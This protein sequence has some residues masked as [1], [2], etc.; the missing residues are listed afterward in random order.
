MSQTINENLASLLSDYQVLYQ[1]LRNYHWNVTGPLFFGL[2][3]KFEELYLD[4]AE[5]VDLLA[6]RISAKG[7]RPPSTLAEHLKLA[8]LQEDPSTPGA[9]DMVKAILDDYEAL[10]KNLRSLSSQAAEAGDVKTANVAD[11]FADGQEKTAWMLRAF[12]GN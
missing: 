8:R 9:N 5:K 1:K 12:L 3:A 2:H 7:N 11:E 6:E 10:N 4:A